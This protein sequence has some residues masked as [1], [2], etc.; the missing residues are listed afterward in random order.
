MAYDTNMSI[1][2]AKAAVDAVV[3]LMDGGTAAN[4]KLRIYSGSQPA[5]PDVA[6]GTG[7]T[8]LAEIDL[9]AATVFGAAATE[10]NSA[11]ATASGILPKTD[12]SANASGT[13]TWFRAVDKD[14]TAIID[15]T[16]GTSGADMVL[17]NTSIAAGQAVKL[18]TWKVKLSKV[19]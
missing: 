1:A 12:T 3:D 4:P 13:A 8:L 7:N 14:A 10:T 6:A 9:G 18:N 11:A 5:S 15:G 2:A 16:V 17:D 19:G